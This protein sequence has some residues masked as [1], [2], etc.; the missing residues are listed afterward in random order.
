MNC[1]I[2]RGQFANNFHIF[3]HIRHGLPGKAGDE[4]H[5]D[6]GKSQLPAVFIHGVNRFDAMAPAQGI[7][8]VLLQGLGMTLMRSTPALRS[9]ASMS[10]VAVSGR[11]ASTVHSRASG[12]FR[13]AASSS[14]PGPAGAGT[15]ASR[16][17]HRATSLP[18]HRSGT[19]RP[20]RRRL[21]RTASRKAVSAASPSLPMRRDGKEQYRQWLGQ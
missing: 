18:G 3:L 4:V 19:S 13:P 16:R 7:E 1:N 2:F 15:S 12:K 8:E 21:A 17:R 11:P 14:L 10:G 20:G 9:M 6:D 5:I